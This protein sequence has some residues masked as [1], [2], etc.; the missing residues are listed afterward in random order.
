[1]NPAFYA[2]APDQIPVCED[3]VSNTH[4]RHF[5]PEHPPICPLDGH[6][7]LCELALQ[8]SRFD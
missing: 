6:S 8:R 2:E 7:A 1:M 5:V 3:A 4:L